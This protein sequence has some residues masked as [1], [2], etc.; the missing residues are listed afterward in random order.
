MDRERLRAF[1]GV[2][3]PLLVAVLLVAVAVNFYL[4][5]NLGDLEGWRPFC[6]A[7][8]M[9]TGAVLILSTYGRYR[10]ARAARGTTRRQ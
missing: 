4:S 9:F 10:K 3:A 7:G 5:A 8:V 1:L 6:T 2:W